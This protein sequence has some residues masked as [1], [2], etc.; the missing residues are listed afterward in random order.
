MDEFKPSNTPE[1]GKSV[2]FYMKYQW[3]EQ[4]KMAFTT[5]C[6]KVK[7]KIENLEIVS[8]FRIKRQKAGTEE[9]FSFHDGSRLG[10]KTCSWR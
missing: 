10:F 2:L 7:R 4:T 1:R 9:F 3:S 8:C 5:V 6:T